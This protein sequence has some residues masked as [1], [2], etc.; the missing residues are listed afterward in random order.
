[1]RERV[2]PEDCPVAGVT[3]RRAGRTKLLTM[4][5]VPQFHLTTSHLLYFVGSDH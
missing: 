3:D 4:A 2:S 1:L 5:K